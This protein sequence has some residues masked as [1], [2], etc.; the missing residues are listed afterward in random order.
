METIAFGPGAWDQQLSSEMRAT[1]IGNA[2]TWLDET[3]DPDALQIELKD[4]AGFDKRALLT[5]GTDSAPFFGPVVDIV[6]QALPHAQRITITGADH[7]PHLS[8]PARYVELV[9]TFAQTGQAD[10][11]ER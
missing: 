6:A 1:F 8:V 11:D 9:R 7:V 5:S 3:R 10:T 4:L 2:P